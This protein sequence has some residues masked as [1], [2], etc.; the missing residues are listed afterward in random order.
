MCNAG[1]RELQVGTAKGLKMVVSGHGEGRSATKAYGLP[2]EQTIFGRSAVMYSIHQKVQKILATDVPILIQGENGTGKGL[3]AQYIHC[4]SVSSSGAFVKVNC[5]AIPGALLESELF[6]YEKGAFTDAFGSK[7]GYVETAHRGTLF[8]DE[9]ADLDMSLQAKILQLLQ[10]GRFSRIG[11]QEQRRAETRIICATNRNLQTEIDAGRFRYDLYYRIN[12]IDIRLPSLRERREDI[13]GLVEYFLEQLTARFDRTVPPISPETM[14]FLRDREWHGNLREL[15][16]CVARYVILGSED[17]FCNELAE[18]G[19]PS[20]TFGATASE[21]IPLK[22]ATKHAIRATERRLILNALQ[23]N[24]WNRRKAAETLN[25]SY[26]ALMYKIR[27]ANLSAKRPRNGNSRNAAE[28]K[29][30]PAE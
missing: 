21:V 16:N 13:K 5:A 29:N 11:D 8:L 17:V 20:S 1:M 25:I 19:R 27:E 28:K 26:R 9:I 2:P 12:V 22:R 4:H 14:R 6:G 15:E 7:P 24:R 10:D 18:K 3:L 30:P 23:E